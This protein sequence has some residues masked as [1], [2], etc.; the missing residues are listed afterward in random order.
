MRR[1]VDTNVL[2]HAVNSRSPHHVKAREFIE[3][4]LGSH[5]P[6]CLTW[7]V[8]YEFLRVAT[9]PRVFEKPLTAA[10]ALAFL[11]P[12]LTADHLSVLAGTGRHLAVLTQTLDEHPRLSANILHDVHTAVLMREHGVG[13]VATADADFNRFAFLRVYNPF[14]S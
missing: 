10:R 2:L 7:P 3:E 9:H 14:A 6:F 1:L 5:A 8:V 12:L 13:E 4:L 11:H